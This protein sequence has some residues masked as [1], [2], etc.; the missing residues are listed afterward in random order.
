MCVC[1]CVCVC[2]LCVCVCCV[3]VCVYVCVCVFV[4]VSRTTIGM[5]FPIRYY[6]HNIS[7]FGCAYLVS[8]FLT[9]LSQREEPTNTSYFPP[10]LLKEGKHTIKATSIIMP[11]SSPVLIHGNGGAGKTALA[12]W[13]MKEWFKGHV[14]T[15]YDVFCLVDIDSMTSGSTKVT[16]AQFLNEHS[17]CKNGAHANDNFER[18]IIWF[19]EYDFDNLLTSTLICMY[20]II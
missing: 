5:V 16:L 12:E 11:G 17:K 18:T 4:C 14:S 20:L 19:G 3:C 7:N 15:D 1:M 9:F 13:T 8:H 10:K 6:I 2:V